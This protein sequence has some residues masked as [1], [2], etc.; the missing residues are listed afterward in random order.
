MLLPQTVVAALDF[1]V[2][3]EPALVRAATLAARAGA[4]LHLVHALAAAPEEHGTDAALRVRLERYVAGAL[5]L[6]ARGFDPLA[7]LAPTLAVVHG[8]TVANAILRYVARV[9]A[10]L[11]VVGTHGRRGLDRLLVGSVAQACVKAAPCPVLTV[12]RGAEAHEPSA[13]APVLVAV[14]FSDLSRAALAVGRELADLHGADVELVHVVREAGP[15][16]GLVP[17]VLDLDAVDPDRAHAV[18]QRLARFAG[19]TASTVHVALG[20]PSRVVAA[21]AE[22]QSAGAVVMGAHGRSGV[23]HAILGSTAGATIQRAPCAVLTVRE[24][25]QRSPV[26]RRAA[27]RPAVAA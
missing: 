23:A 8:S 16:T 9:D 17:T 25:V 27:R 13:Q 6:P 11:L 10:D 5:G 14:D 15:F 4:A 2:G 12:P 20:P 19:G 3:A 21:L 26:R 18:R 24:T 1:S 7:P 22:T